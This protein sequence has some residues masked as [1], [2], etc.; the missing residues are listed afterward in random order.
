MSKMSEKAKT[1]AYLYRYFPLLK[2]L[3]YVMHAEAINPP[4]NAMTLIS[5]LHTKFRN[6]RLAFEAMDISCP[7]QHQTN[8]KTYPT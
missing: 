1:Y 8:P 5:A 6:L 3:V 7:L 4:R 2:T